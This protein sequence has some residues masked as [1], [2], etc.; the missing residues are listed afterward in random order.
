VLRRQDR[1]DL[2]L[3]RLEIET[4]AF[5]RVSVMPEGLLEGLADDD[6]ADLFAH[7]AT[8]R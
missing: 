7:L 4:S 1:E 6:V 3:E 2:R 5:E 8:L